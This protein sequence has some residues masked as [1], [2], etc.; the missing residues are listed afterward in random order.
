MVA[1]SD[2]P[3]PSEE[4]L[5]KPAPLR[6]QLRQSARGRSFGLEETP[7]N[8]PADEP[9]TPR[10]TFARSIGSRVNSFYSA[11]SRLPEEKTTPID[12][13]PDGLHA[14][15]GWVTRVDVPGSRGR[16][17]NRRWRAT[18]HRGR[19]V[20]AI[21]SVIAIAMSL[22]SV[23]TAVLGIRFSACPVRSVVARSRWRAA[24]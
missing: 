9:G 18:A 22:R 8:P 19:S 5:S 21:S 1:Q 15:P 2:I 7:P 4:C 24:S 14:L 17:V 6:H 20:P 12:A 13:N 3:L 10:S 11:L 23:T 16:Q